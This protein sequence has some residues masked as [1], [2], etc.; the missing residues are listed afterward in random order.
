MIQKKE[1]NIQLFAKASR[2][3]VISLSIHEPFKRSFASDGWN[4]QIPRTM[5][6]RDYS[7]A[8]I[9]TS[10]SPIMHEAEC[11]MY[12]YLTNNPQECHRSALIAVK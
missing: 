2:A 9:Q 1:K 8:I 7:A 5:N 12:L 4:R 3:A 11:N 10:T 6:R